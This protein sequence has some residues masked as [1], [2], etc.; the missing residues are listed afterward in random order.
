MKEQSQLISDILIA[1]DGNRPECDIYKHC[2]SYDRHVYSLY[3]VRMYDVII[4]AV[5]CRLVCVHIVYVNVYDEIVLCL[6]SIT[7]YIVYVPIL[8]VNLTN[9]YNI[10]A[11][12]ILSHYV[13]FY[14]SNRCLHFIFS[15]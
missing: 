3:T 4:N 15:S 2:Q 11:W 10:L 8:Y 7:L 1:S 6:H 13:L 5:T 14:F 12:C 9:L